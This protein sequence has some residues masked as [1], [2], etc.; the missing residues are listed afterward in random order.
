MTCH[1][2]H[3]RSAVRLGAP[4]YSYYYPVQARA[5]SYAA[6]F[7]YAAPPVYQAQPISVQ[8]APQYSYAQAPPQNVVVQQTPVVYAQSPP[9]Q[10]L[11]QQQPQVVYQQPPIVQNP[12]VVTVAQQPTRTVYLQEPPRTVTVQQQPSVILPP[13]SPPQT[14]IVTSTVTVRPLPSTVI[15]RQPPVTVTVQAR[16]TYQTPSRDQQSSGS[17]SY[18]K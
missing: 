1:S 9:Q 5:V 8:A 12:S 10:V 6:P 2:C 14:V 3:F 15:V 4:A 16:H 11:V 18:G 7:S 17:G 13:R